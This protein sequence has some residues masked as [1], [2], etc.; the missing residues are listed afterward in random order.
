MGFKQGICEVTYTLG[1][2][3]IPISNFDSINNFTGVVG[4]I[5]S[6]MDTSSDYF[7]SQANVVNRTTVVIIIRNTS[8]VKPS[9]L[10]VWT[11]ILLY[12]LAD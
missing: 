5:A 1:R 11:S 7:V 6:L 8:N 3:E 9:S 12:G 2:A 10:T 4:V